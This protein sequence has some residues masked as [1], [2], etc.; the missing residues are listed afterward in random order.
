MIYLKIHNTEDGIILAM[1]DSTLINKVLTEGDV[2]INIRDYSEFYKGKLIDKNT[3]VDEIE[4][5]EV[6]SATIIGKESIE[7][8]IQKTLIDQESVKYVED[9]PYA[10]M[11]RIEYDSK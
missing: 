11:Y 4:Y 8:A 6:Y 1:C 2:E 5:S 7:I 3:A 9:V 10:N